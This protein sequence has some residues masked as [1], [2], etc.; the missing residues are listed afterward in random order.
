M[1]VSQDPA[2][3]DE[4]LAYAR[5]LEWGTHFGLAML[6]A[7]SCLYLLGVV[8]PHVPLDQLGNLW[9]LPVDEYRAAVGAPSGW[10]WLALAGR[11][12]YLNYFGIGFLAGVTGL[13]YLR[14]VP[15]LFARGHRAQAW[16][17]VVEIGVLA[18]A[19]AG[20]AAGH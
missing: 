18:L 11:G 16:L 1:D 17:V 4:Q 6:I 19:I 8:A 20:P 13:C 5:W 9:G 14:I 7:S 15:I 10:A 3:P 12:D 2:A